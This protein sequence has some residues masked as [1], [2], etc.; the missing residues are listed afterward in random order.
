MFFSSLRFAI[1]NMVF[2]GILRPS[3]VSVAHGDPPF[4]ESGGSSSEA[5][6]TERIRIFFPLKNT[7]T[8]DEFSDPLS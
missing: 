1:C 7:N 3:L 5:P 6:K 8:P 4:E 2:S